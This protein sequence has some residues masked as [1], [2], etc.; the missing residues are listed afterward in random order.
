MQFTWQKYAPALTPLKNPLCVPWGARPKPRGLP[1]PPSS[2]SSSSGLRHQT[3][4][5]RE[6]EITSH[7]FVPRTPTRGQRGCFS[8]QEL[9]GGGGG[10]MERLGGALAGGCE[11]PVVVPST[12]PASA[13]ACPETPLGT[14]FQQ[15]HPPPSIATA[16]QGGTSGVQTPA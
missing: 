7:R 6:G 12:A 1:S 2:I 9:W 14:V 4:A 13:P 3:A 15:H 5:I 11:A 10:G 16:S 8:S